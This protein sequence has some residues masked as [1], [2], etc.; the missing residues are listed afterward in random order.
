MDNK[1]PAV[2]YHKDGAHV[3]VNSEAEAKAL[4]PGYADK[5]NENTTRALRKASGASKT[6]MMPGV[7]TRS[8]EE[9]F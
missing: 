3:V 8:N 6:D 5:P 7:I 4:P 1:Y 2:L 9:A